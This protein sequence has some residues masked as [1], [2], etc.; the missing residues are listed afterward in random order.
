MDQPIKISCYPEF[1]PLGLPICFLVDQMCQQKATLKEVISWKGK[2]NIH[3]LA[4]SFHSGHQG[5]YL[6]SPGHGSE[7][8]QGTAGTCSSY[9]KAV[10]FGLFV[11]KSFRCGTVGFCGEGPLEGWNVPVP[12]LEE[13]L[14]K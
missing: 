8:A 14:L 3:Q 4:E 6:N 1:W 10:G 7:R 5:F 13:M 9:R 11:V 12:D 2:G